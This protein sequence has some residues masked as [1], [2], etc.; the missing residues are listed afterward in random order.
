M[1]PANGSI[2]VF[3]SGIGGLSVANAV[4]RLLP[5]ESILYVADNGRAP[6]GPQPPEAILAYSREITT[7]LL[8]SGA[9]MI[10]VACNTATAVAIDALRQEYP[11]VPFVGME[12]ALKPAAEGK[13]IGVLA[14]AA[15]LSSER[16]LALKDRYLS[17]QEVLED[18]CVGL[19]PIIEAEV[20][21]SPRL[22]H[23][24]KKI[25][26][27]MVAKGI[28]T[29]V[30]GC[31]HYPMVQADIAAVCGENVRIIDPSVAAAKQV[32]R[33]LP[34]PFVGTSGRAH[35]F[36]CTGGSVSLQRTL[37]GLPD[38]NGDRALVVPN[39][40]LKNLPNGG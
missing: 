34:Y 32:A 5:R 21:G 7:A 36:Y 15:T 35:N 22:R 23:T 3:D 4:S 2:G 13:R 20:P 14:T 39:L 24:L 28:D 37:L 6:Y 30:L 10:V 19:V 33:L 40:K 9:K 25:L 26:M 1:N 17:K 31:T 11:A 8:A 16:Y 29:L 38:L 18:A 27:P 12:P